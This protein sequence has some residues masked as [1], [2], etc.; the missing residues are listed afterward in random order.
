[1]GNIGDGMKSIR[2]TFGLSRV[3]EPAGVVPVAAW[4]LDNSREISE[5]ECLVELECIHVE[6][7]SFQQICSEC[8]FD[9]IK[10]KAKI[11]DIINKRGKLHNPFT[12]SGG[13][14]CGKVVEMGSEYS[15]DTELEKG[16]RII[17]LTSMTAMPIFIDEIYEIDYNYGQLMVSGYAILFESSPVTEL[18]ATSEVNY[19][20]SSI[21]EA[22]SLCSVFNIIKPGMK[23]M[24]IGKD[25]LSA[26]MYLDIAHKASKGDCTLG[27]L[28][29]ETTAEGIP[30]GNLNTILGI[31]SNSIYVTD[32]T[33][34]VKAADMILSREQSLYD[35]TIN[36]EDLMGAE[37]IAVL[38]TKAKG[39]ISFTSVQNRYT[40]AVLF[41][42]S[43]GKELQIRALDQYID[44]Y[45]SFSMG[46]IDSLKKELREIAEI[47]NV[48]HEE[49]KRAVKKAKY[50]TIEKSGKVD[51]FIFAS[52]VTENLIDEVLNIAG[53]D[54]NVILQGETGT[55]KEK[56][57]S[58]IHKNSSRRAKPCVKI[59]CAT[60]Q[61]NLAE[62]E[63]FGYESGSF[64]GAQSHGK[65]G[66]FDM[67]NGGILFLDEVGTLSLNLQSKLLRVIQEGEFMRVGGLE[68]IG[69]NVRVICAN[70]VPLR[71]LVED[72]SFREDLYYR[73]NICTINIPPLRERKDDI[74]A[75][76]NAF[77]EKYCNM[78]GTDK[79]LDENAAMRLTEYD[80]PG[81]VRELENFVHRL[82]INVKGH[83]VYYEDVENLLNEALYENLVMDLKYALKGEN[84]VDFNKIIEEQEK[85]LVSYGLKKCGTTRKAADFLNMTQAQLMRKKQKYG[86]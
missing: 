26:V 14:F 10:I 77:M 57:L 70:N 38:I 15:S 55:G 68:P 34:P 28:I 25:L 41:A 39:I 84:G 80:W 47:Y 44:D 46:I 56:I 65:R 59:N 7:D 82:V 81:N 49:G 50:I 2:D 62:S 72:G 58:L 74:V 42:E 21:D 16:M 67:A 18:K 1:M 86:L 43:L 12:D 19:M 29:D 30:G 24:V 76:A 20:L 6:H 11:I 35:M 52:K 36:C 85:Q 64:T 48:R 71:Q 27:V 32:I 3:V 45:E 66:Y 31:Y 79:E 78:Y 40:N 33:Q 69:V 75:L 23:V 53:Y 83:I 4:K 9:D 5:N 37:S 63:F 60:I 73:L 13:I 8:G 17:G 54:C 51:D 61:E 22:G